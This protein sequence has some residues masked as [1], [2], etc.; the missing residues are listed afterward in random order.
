MFTAIGNIL[1]ILCI[2]SWFI[3]CVVAILVCMMIFF[4][5]IGLAG[6]QLYIYLHDG[7][8]MPVST[9]DGFLSIL[10]WFSASGSTFTLWLTKPDTWIGLHEIF[11]FIPMSIFL[12]VFPWL[13]FFLFYIATKD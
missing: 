10:N 8:W 13:L 7:Y 4:S 12:F 6:Y 3:C 2:G 1:V 11:S 5:S 9:I